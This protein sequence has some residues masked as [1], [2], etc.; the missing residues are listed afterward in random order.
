MVDFDFGMSEGK[1]AILGEEGVNG[2]EGSE[3]REEGVNRK[4][5]GRVSDHRPNARK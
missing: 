5:N 4:P 1:L 3:A 2:M